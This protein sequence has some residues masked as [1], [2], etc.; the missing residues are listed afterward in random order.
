MH[1]AGH[2]GAHVLAQDRKGT[3]EVIRWS[4]T[5]MPERRTSGG[6][7]GW[8]LA[9]DTSTEQAGLA[10]T[11]GTRT[12]EL[13]WP[14]GRMQTVSVLPA[15]KYLLQLCEV[16]RSALGAIAVATGP[17]TFTGLR[18]GLSLAKGFTLARDLPIVGVPT[19]DV[20]AAPYARAGI[21]VAVVIAAGRGRI[22][23]AAYG[24]GE[25]FGPDHGPLN[26][27]NDALIGWLRDHPHVLVAGELSV[28]DRE[29][30]TA[31]G[32]ARIEDAPLTARRPGALAALGWRRW[33]AGDVDDA[34]ALEPVYL[35][36]ARQGAI[37]P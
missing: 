37:D 21:P 18:V 13:L 33:Q 4:L 8:L 10:L 6:S 17:G 35:H 2:D 27:R 26:T 1:N 14:A 7:T 16:E 22:V 3:S 5:H 15:I 12:A 28:T 19:L 36:A 29:E 32:H 25:A 11:N 34:A 9:I 23:W 24:L 20:A 30:I 31:A